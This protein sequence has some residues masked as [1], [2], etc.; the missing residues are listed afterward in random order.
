MHKINWPKT[1][2]HLIYVTITQQ[3][4]CNNW[5]DKYHRVQALE[6]HETLWRKTNRKKKSN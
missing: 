4:H 6:K 1:F 5:L 2:S 3:I